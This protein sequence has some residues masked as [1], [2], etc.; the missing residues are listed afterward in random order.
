MGVDSSYKATSTPLNLKSKVPRP[1]RGRWEEEHYLL[2]VG[3]SE[4]S[5]IF[6]FVL[7]RN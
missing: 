1:S 5:K 4:K 7:E 3:K 2:I 6:V